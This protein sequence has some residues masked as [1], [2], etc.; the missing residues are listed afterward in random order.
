MK[1]KISMLMAAVLVFSA[2]FSGSARTVSAVYIRPF[3]DA[4]DYSLAEN[5]LYDG[6]YPEN[7]VDVFMV[8]PT[9]DTLNETNSVITP[10]YKKRF[11]NAM[12][13]Q[14]A[15]FA[16]TAKIYA[17]YY[18]QCAM[19]V[20]SMD[21]ASYEKCAQNAYMDVSAAFKYY[22]EHKNK[23]RPIILAGYSQGADMCYRILEEYYGG[24]GERAVWLRDNLIAV[25][26]IGWTL[27]EE[28]TAKYPQMVPAQGETDTGVIITYDCEDGSVTDSFITHAGTKA[29]SINPLNWKADSTKAD[30]SLNRGT[31]TQDS[32]TGA[33]TSMETGKYG[34]YI[35][36]SRG[37]LIVTDIDTSQYP[38]IFDVFPD[39]SLHLYDNFLF[40]VNL[41]ENVKKRTEAFLAKLLDKA[42]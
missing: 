21:A 8:A 4:L 30:K 39:G 40:F 11:R 27:T 7:S 34:A 14:Q 17:P 32:K 37:T 20:Y 36:P 26:A 33:I 24:D 13:Q 12:N 5:W 23:G 28:M 41:Q 22:L 25:Y 19:N 9:V 29:L 1:K 38:K 6:A 3:D 2:L 31:V 42:A 16:Y 15:I 10:E 18:R 35:D